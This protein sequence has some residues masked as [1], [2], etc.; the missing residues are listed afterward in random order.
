MPLESPLALAIDDALVVRASH[1][2]AQGAPAELAARERAYA[3]R[4]TG[5]VARFAKLVE[6]GGGLVV[7]GPSGEMSVELGADLKPRD[8]FALAE[9]TRAVLVEVLPLG[10]AFS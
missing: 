6:D 8:L 9:D 4:A 7:P 1:V 2:V 10:R 3:V 5:D